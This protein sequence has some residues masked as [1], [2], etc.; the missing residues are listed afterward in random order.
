MAA[1]AAA[2]MPAG[3]AAAGGGAPGDEVMK[4]VKWTRPAV[5]GAPPPPRGGHAGV[6]V[7][8]LFIVFGGTLYKGDN[9]FAYLN[10]TWALDVDTM[11]WHLP[12]CAGRPP[13]GRYGHA[14]VV[15][16]YKV[17]IFGGKGEGGILYNDL[18]CLD[19]EKWSWAMIPSSTA[20]PPG[21]RCGHSMIAVGDKLAV[22]GGW[23]GRVANN[24]FWLFDMCTCPARRSGVLRAFCCHTTHICSPAHAAA[25]YT[26]V[27]PGT[28]GVPPC[29]RHGH[30]AVRRRWRGCTSRCAATP[31]PP[32]PH[33]LR[34]PQVYDEA[35]ARMLVY[36]GWHPGDDGVP[37]Y[38]G[39]TRQLDLHTLTW[40]RPRAL[41][42]TPGPRYAHGVAMVGNVLVTTGGYDGPRDAAAVEAALPK[43]LVTIPYAPGMGGDALAGPGSF[44]DVPYGVHADTCFLNMDAGEWIQ[45]A[46]AGTPPGYRYGAAVAATG[47]HVLVFGGWEGGR[48]LNDLI[49]LDMTALVDTE[50]G[51][52]DG[53]GGDG[54]GDATA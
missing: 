8:N 18:W 10:D 21:T 1:A 26:W 27:R 16:D 51:G 40:S 2:A 23:D 11:K 38:Q 50:D 52:G 29:A 49:V 7:G 20:A 33:P 15:V 19:V 30:C 25:S 39:D 32:P 41:G 14:A 9:K 54:G 28:S 36:G 17:Y 53:S 22:F 6:M 48:P 34:S 13:G 12:K 3:D 42:A 37:E 44:I 35:S 43:E 46:L 31:T 4:V 24:E 47:A 45:P 5:F